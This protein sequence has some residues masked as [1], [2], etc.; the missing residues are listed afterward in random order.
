MGKTER[1]AVVTAASVVKALAPCA[2]ISEE[3]NTQIAE[4]GDGWG[5]VDGWCGGDEW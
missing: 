4:T 1:M 3:T 5:W 2:M